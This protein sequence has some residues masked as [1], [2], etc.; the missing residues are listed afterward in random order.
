MVPRYVRMIRA[1][2]MGIIH[3]YSIPPAKSVVTILTP[4]KRTYL[5]PLS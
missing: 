3:H 2:A 4:W 1:M 5:D